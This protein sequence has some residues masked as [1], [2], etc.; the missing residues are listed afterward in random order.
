MPFVYDY[1]VDYPPAFDIPAAEPA[2]DDDTDWERFDD[3]AEFDVDSD[4]F[5][6][7]EEAY[8]FYYPE[9]TDDGC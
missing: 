1:V 7:P 9:E 2:E 4:D 8:A 5:D 3:M 6:T